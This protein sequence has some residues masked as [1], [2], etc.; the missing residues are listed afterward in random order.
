MPLYFA[1][2]TTRSGFT[3]HRRLGLGMPV[4]HFRTV[5]P[6]AVVVPHEA[7]CSNPGCRYLHRMAALVPGFGIH[8][9]GEVFDVADFAA[10]DALE[11]AGP[12]ERA[13]VAVT[14]GERELVAAAY[15]VREPGMWRELVAHGR[16]DALPAYPRELARVETLKPCCERDPGHPPPHDVLMPR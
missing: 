2:G 9:E 11:L 16:A 10:T 1:Y 15:P 6:Y 4:G 5:E 7:A 8:A 13:E 3:H 12:Y 14:D